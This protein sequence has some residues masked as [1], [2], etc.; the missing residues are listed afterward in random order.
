MRDDLTKTQYLDS[1]A[2]VL[3]LLGSPKIEVSDLIFH[4]EHLCEAHFKY[5]DSFKQHDI[6]SNVVIAAFTTAYARLEL[7]DLMHKLGENLLY[8]DTDSACYIVKKDSYRPTLGNYLGQLTNEIDPKDGKYIKTFVGAGPKSYA[9]QLD[10]GKTTVKL[11]G[12]TLNYNA[13]KIINY[14]TL[15]EMVRPGTDLKSVRVDLPNTIT[16]QPKSKTIVNKDTHKDYRVVYTKRVI[17]PNGF[18]TLPYGYRK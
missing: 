1:P 2:A 12:I 18:D 15:K 6:H 8:G 7:Y 5:L 9:Y 3:G 17:Q 10:S 11:K 14:E 16:R 13:R 4:N